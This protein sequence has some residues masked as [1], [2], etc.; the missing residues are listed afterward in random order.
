[1]MAMEEDPY[2]MAFHRIP[3]ESVRRP[4]HVTAGA[5]RTDAIRE[6]ERALEI[7]ALLAVQVDARVRLS[8]ELVKQVAV[9][10]L[11]VPPGGLGVRRLSE[12]TFLLKF[13]NQQMRNAARNSTLRVGHTG[14]QLLPW[15]RRAG[16]ANELAKYRYHARLCIEGI[17]S[18]ARQPETVANLFKNPVFIDDFHCAKEKPEEEFCL[19]LWAWTSDPDGF[20]KT[21]TLEIAEPVTL[22]EEYYDELSEDYGMPTAVGRF[23]AAELL[24]YPVIIHL[25]RILDYSPSMDPDEPWPVRHPFLWRLGVPDGGAVG[26]RV[27]V[28]ERLGN[29]NRPESPPR[30]GGAGGVGPGMHHWPAPR[31]QDPGVF[32]R[33]M[34]QGQSSGGGGHGGHYRRR[35]GPPVRVWKVRGSIPEAQVTNDM[36][37]NVDRSVP[38][39]SFLASERKTDEHCWVDPMLEEVSKFSGPKRCQP[40]LLQRSVEPTATKG[41]TAASGQLDEDGFGHMDLEVCRDHML[42]GEEDSV[43]DNEDTGAKAVHVVLQ[44]SDIQLAR[45]AGGEESRRELFD[46]NL[47][48]KLGDIPEDRSPEANINTNE[49]AVLASMQER[50]PSRPVLGGAEERL[51][52]ESTH[53]TSSKGISRFSVPLRKALLCTPAVRTKATHPRKHAAADKGHKNKGSGSTHLPLEEKATSILLRAADIIKEGE[54]PTDETKEHFVEQFI[55]PM[56]P[57]LVGNMRDVFGLTMNGIGHGLE[58]LAA[59]ADD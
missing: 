43:Q 48:G 14:L 51:N 42:V 47:S 27:P 18:H 35:N 55:D 49:C 16:A 11:R 41:A 1:M 12:V 59:D 57:D 53:K 15:S 28:H 29:Q 2:E 5:P 44:G 45:T 21:G 3:G 54:I 39:D 52:K 22:P 25:D 20:A 36:V 31:M 40:M 7:Y 30:G 26:R 17:P 9:R 13:D 23:D 6:E 19:C 46:L 37:S 10:Q 56:Q 32:G 8:T 38:V 4:D 33:A 50:P 24:K 34:R 58:V